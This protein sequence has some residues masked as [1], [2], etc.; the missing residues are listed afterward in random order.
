MKAT[1]SRFLKIFER[2]SPNRRNHVRVSA[3]WPATVIIGESKALLGRVENIG[4]GGA[5]LY[6]TEKL[7]SQCPIRIAVEMPDCHDA[8]TA[9]GAVVRSFSLNRGNGQPFSFAVAVEFS[10]IS[11]KDLRFF[12]GNLA[13]EW[14]ENCLE[15]YVDTKETGKSHRSKYT[16]GKYLVFGMLFVILSSSIYL[17]PGLKKEEKL[18]VHQ[19]V[20]L[21][22]RLKKT[23]LQ[24]Q[25]LQSSNVALEKIEGKV[26]N[27]NYD[28]LNVKSRIPEIEELAKIKGQLDSNMQKKEVSPQVIDNSNPSTSVSTEKTTT[29][30]HAIYHKVKSGENLYR[31]SLSYGLTVD[32]IRRLNNLNKSDKILLGQKLK[33][34]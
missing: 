28:M 6:L 1:Q 4:R 20:Q 9:E 19:I 24:L 13:P 5:L 14:Q 22:E 26:D 21:D 30:R 16:T 23:E 27:L 10:Q 29:R 7:R 18:V 25:L 17:M 12:S 8:I 2:S 34:K 33:V 11:D 3:T 32:D 31:I 15:T